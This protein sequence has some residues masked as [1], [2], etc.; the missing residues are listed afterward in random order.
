MKLCG[1]KKKFD[2]DKKESKSSKGPKDKMLIK[3]SQNAS[4]WESVRSQTSPR[5]ERQTVGKSTKK[6][7][8]LDGAD[9]ER[10]EVELTSELK[11]VFEK[12]VDKNI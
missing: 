1:F 9:G 11:T 2:F 7:K 4:E 8:K 3:T 10:D 5:S 12:I 6:G